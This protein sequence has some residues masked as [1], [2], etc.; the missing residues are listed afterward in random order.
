MNTAENKS[1]AWRFADALG[2]IARCIVGGMF[3]YM[4][5]VKALHP[6]DFLKLVREYDIIHA[7]PALNLIA[8]ALP[9]FEV[10]CGL[11]LVAG[12]AVRGTALVGVLMLVPFTVLVLLRTIEMSRAEGLSLCAIKFDCGCGGGEIWI[13]R[14]LVENL[15]LT[16][17]SAWL[18]F[19]RN[20]RLCL[21]HQLIRTP[22]T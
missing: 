8:A 16:L 18:I 17:L 1:R 15:M 14:K 19:S 21:R 22:S 12:I 4:G 2:V 10:F 20:E 13:C 11:L 3:I 5:V 7:P 6:V 9:W